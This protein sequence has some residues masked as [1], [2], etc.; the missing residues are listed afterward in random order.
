MLHLPILVAAGGI[1]SAGRTSHRHGFKRMVIEQLSQ[2][3][4]RDTR[5]ALSNL[6]G[7][8]E[9]HQQ[10][11]G[12]LI[13]AIESTHFSPGALPWARRINLDQSMTA[14][15]SATQVMSGL[16][17]DLAPS[18]VDDRRTRV[19]LPHNAELLRFICR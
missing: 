16:S 10:D 8:N 1:N 19:S 14:T 17:P 13:R 4:Q 5:H 11:A 18:L 3:D 2:T 7:V 12:T 9:A 6:M 15:M